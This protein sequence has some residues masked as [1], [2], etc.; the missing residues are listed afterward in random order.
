MNIH[1]HIHTYIHAYIYMYAY[2]YMHMHLFRWIDSEDEKGKRKT[3]KPQQPIAQ[4]R[5]TM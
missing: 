3:D 2:I 4:W 5:K 1:T